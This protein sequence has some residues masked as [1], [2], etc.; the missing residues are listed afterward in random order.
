MT[1]CCCWRQPRSLGGRICRLPLSKVFF[2]SFHTVL[3]EGKS[4]CQPVLRRVSCVPSWRQSVHINYW[5]FLCRGVCLF[6]PFYLTICLHQCRLVDIYFI[7]QV[8]V[9]WYII[10]FL[11]QFVP[12]FATL[13]LCLAPSV[14]V[15]V[16]CC[17]CVI[18]CPRPILFFPSLSKNQPFLWE[19][20]VPLLE[21]GVRTQYLAYISSFLFKIN[22]P[23]SSRLWNDSIFL[24]SIFSLSNDNASCLHNNFYEWTDFYYI[25]GFIATDHPKTLKLWL[26]SCCCWVLKCRW[27]HCPGLLSRG[28]HFLEASLQK[29]KNLNTW[30]YFVTQ[31]LSIKEKE[32]VWMENS[33]PS[34]PQLPGSWHLGLNP[35]CVFQTPAHFSN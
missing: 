32:E 30:Y 20:R 11:A 15:C 34:G 26:L 19:A 14:H 29:F 25:T 27:W 8:T 12:P 22:E 18:F 33:C 21:N 17:V 23:G 5:G 28:D 2:F 35:R 13:C 31:P 6:S 9:Q 4:L 3:F 10:N 24:T 16:W 7:I 1:S